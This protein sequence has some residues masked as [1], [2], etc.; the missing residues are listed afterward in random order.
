MELKKQTNT[1]PEHILNALSPS[2]TV[3]VSPKP[4]RDANFLL[5]HNQIPPDCAHSRTHKPNEKKGPFEKTK[6]CLF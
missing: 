1:E 2:L 5:V 6:H 4:T 3:S